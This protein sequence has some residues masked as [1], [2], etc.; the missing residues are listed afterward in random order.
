MNCAGQRVAAGQQDLVQARQGSG[1]GLGHH[2]VPAQE[3]DRVLH[4]AFLVA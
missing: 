4:V 2:Q 3:T 1:L